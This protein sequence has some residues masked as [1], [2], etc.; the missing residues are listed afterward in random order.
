MDQIPGS[1][2]FADSIVQKKSSTNFWTVPFVDNKR[3]KNISG[4]ALCNKAVSFMSIES[5]FG[6]MRCQY[7]SLSTSVLINGL[8]LLSIG[9]NEFLV[10]QEI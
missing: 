9:D 8:L 2:S 4:I 5:S 6:L 3:V 10:L 1:V 7:L